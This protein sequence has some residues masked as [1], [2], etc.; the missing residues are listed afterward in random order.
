MSCSVSNAQR[1]GWLSCVK[2]A[3]EWIHLKEEE[4]HRQQACCFLSS[5]DEW[6]FLPS[7]VRSQTIA[8]SL[9]AASSVCSCS[10]RHYRR[11]PEDR[12][13]EGSECNGSWTHHS[14]ISPAGLHQCLPFPHLLFYTSAVTYSQ[15]HFQPVMHV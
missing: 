15:A 1:N 12:A 10:C 9:A 14:G 11:E 6:V 3:Q 8:G 5:I 2:D 13:A 4:P 7:P